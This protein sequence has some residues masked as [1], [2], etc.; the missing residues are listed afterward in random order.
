MLARNLGAMAQ[1]SLIGYWTDGAF[2]G[3]AYFDGYYMIIPRC[4]C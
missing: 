1:V 2:L 3:L 4:S